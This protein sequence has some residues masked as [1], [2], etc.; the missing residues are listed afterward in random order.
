MPNYPSS[1][2][3]GVAPGERSVDNIADF[4]EI[5]DVVAANGEP[6]LSDPTDVL[7]DFETLRAAV[8]TLLGDVDTSISACSSGEKDYIVNVLGLSFNAITYKLRSLAFDV[9]RL[10][11]DV[12]LINSKGVLGTS[13]YPSGQNRGY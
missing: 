4:R 9:N 7:A 13:R 8:V 1:F 10:I 5:K 6:D 11:D 2:I 3:S 12:D